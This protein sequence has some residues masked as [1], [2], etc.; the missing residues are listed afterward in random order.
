MKNTQEIVKKY[1]SLYRLYNTRIMVIFYI[2]GLKIS[3]RPIFNLN[4][5]IIWLVFICSYSYA[6]SLNFLYDTKTDKINK[7]EN[8]FLKYKIDLFK[9]KKLSGA[10]LITG[11]V[12]C[13]FTASPLY[14]QIIYITLVISGYLYSYPVFKL[15][16]KAFYKLFL[17]TLNYCFLPGLLGIIQNFTKYSLYTIL[18]FSLFYSS[19]LLYTDV[20]DIKGDKKVG[21]NTF[22]VILGLKKLTM[23]SATI[24]ISAV[25]IV[26]YLLIINDT[27]ILIILYS[28]VLVQ[29]A[30]IIKRNWLTNKIYKNIVGYYLLLSFLGITLLIK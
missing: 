1:L 28:A 3:H 15:S 30:L 2:L 4:T 11:F 23:L 19:W 22:A 17:M 25:F 10:I 24:S 6:S 9:I 26:S 12:L 16:H 27:K 13:F 29:G 18:T 7:R 5:I 21:K 8:I 14:T 20:K